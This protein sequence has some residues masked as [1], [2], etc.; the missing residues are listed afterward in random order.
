MKRLF[1]QIILLLF[2][3]TGISCADDK[4][5]NASVTLNFPYTKNSD[6]SSEI[7][8]VNVYIF[9]SEG[10]F[11][12]DYCVSTDD[13]RNNNNSLNI[14]LHPGIYDFIVWGN[15]TDY[16][17]VCSLQK[18]VTNFK[19]CDLIFANDGKLL[20][21]H[22][23]P[24][25]YGASYKVEVSSSNTISLDLKRNTKVVHLTVAGYRPVENCSYNC[26]LT[27]INTGY[28]F[29]NSVI[30]TKKLEY[31]P[32]IV[33]NEK[34]E[35]VA[36]FVFMNGLEDDLKDSKLILSIDHPNGQSDELFN[37]ALLEMLL[38]ISIPGGFDSSGDY[39]LEIFMD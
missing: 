14:A 2:V 30:N 26:T 21:C 25:Y 19:D 33:L 12:E 22:P 15:L 7:E 31:R 3:L 18:G 39:D 23:T 6:L 4:D 16:Y 35:L 32:E 24:L 20:E 27:S 13:L 10:V 28:R 8:K 36:N 1:S 9:N 38:P 37:S 34:N 11:V 5:D 17:A 29:D